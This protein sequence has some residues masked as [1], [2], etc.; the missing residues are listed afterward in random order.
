M[1][2]D[3]VRGT[4]FSLMLGDA[5]SPEIFVALCGITTRTFRAQVNTSDQ[6][7]RDCA[8]PEDVPIRRLITTGKQWS[9]SGNGVLNR[10]QLDVIQA[11]LGVTRNYR[12]VY[13]E[14]A[15]DEVF[16]GYW[17]GPAKLVSIEETGSDDNFATIALQVESDGEWAWVEV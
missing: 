3:I 10:A 16:Q 14:P 5:A 4:Y 2:P 13:T 6:Y 1:Q 15:D 12:F 17:A 8:D 7:T 11:A 9:L